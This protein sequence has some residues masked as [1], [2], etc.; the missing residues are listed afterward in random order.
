MVDPRRLPL[1]PTALGRSVHRLQDWVVR[2]LSRWQKIVYGLAAAMLV[3]LGLIGIVLPVLPGLVFL[4]LAA[5]LLARVSPRFGHWWYQKPV[6]Q[7]F[8]RKQQQLKSAWPGVWRRA[9]RSSGA[10]VVSL[11]QILLRRSWRLGGA[12]GAWVGKPLRRVW[13]SRFARR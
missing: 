8:A 2:P 10:A 6:V 7:G 11:A 12:F 4:A 9:L 1:V 3:L 5:G 13:R